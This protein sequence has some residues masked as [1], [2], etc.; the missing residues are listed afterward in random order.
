MKILEIII[1]ESNFLSE[2]NLEFLIKAE[3][4]LLSDTFYPYPPPPINYLKYEINIINKTKDNFYYLIALE[5]MN[6]IGVFKVEINLTKKNCDIVYV[7]MNVLKH[8][9]RQGIGKKLIS[10]FIS[11]FSNFYNYSQIEFHLRSDLEESLDLFIQSIKAQL[12]YTSRRSASNLKSFNIEE[13]RKKALQLEEQNKNNGFEIVFVKNGTFDKENIS[14]EEFVKLVE[15]MKNS[16]PYEDRIHEKVVLK[17]EEYKKRYEKT[18]LLDQESYTFVAIDNSNKIPVAFTE[19]WFKLSQPQIV[20]QADTGVLTSFRGKKLGLTLKYRMLE[21]L[22]TYEKTI[23]ALY[24]STNN[25]K[26]NKYMLAINNELNYEENGIFKVYYLSKENL[27]E[28]VKK[29]TINQ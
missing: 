27:I 23:N 22:L 1:N 13:V 25:A 18:N 20:S 11:N 24:W 26:S 4:I 21:F 16:M 3:T 14:F 7:E 2:E 19:S 15:H 8:L 10:H 12:A 9:R 29:G 28:L 17:V 6:V 5:E